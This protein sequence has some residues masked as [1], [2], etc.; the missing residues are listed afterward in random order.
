MEIT[1][2]LEKVFADVLKVPQE[3]VTDQ[4]APENTPEW[5]SLKAMELVFA[6]EGAFSVRLSTKEI[7]SMRSVGIARTVLRSKGV[8]NI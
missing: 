8:Q 1:A 5:D 6:L 7:V 3:K 2:Q 4:T